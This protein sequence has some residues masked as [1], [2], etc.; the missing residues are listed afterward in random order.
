MGSKNSIQHVKMPLEFTYALL[1]WLPSYLKNLNSDNCLT[2]RWKLCAKNAKNNV[3]VS[4]CGNAKANDG[5]LRPGR[6]P[7]QKMPNL[8][9][10]MSVGQTSLLTPLFIITSNGTLIVPNIL[11]PVGNRAQVG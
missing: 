7:V 2:G 1:K 3:H 6:V 5:K 9:G 11:I 8:L 10:C 4:P